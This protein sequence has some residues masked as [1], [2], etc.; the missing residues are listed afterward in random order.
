MI[1][2][3]RVSGVLLHPSS[4]PGKFGIG[5]LGAGAYSFVDWLCDAGQ[6]IWQILPLGPT[7]WSHSPYQAYSAFA[8]NPDL[9][10]LDFLVRDGYLGKGLIE[11]PPAFPSRKI[12]FKKVLPYRDRLLKM[13]FDQFKVSGGFKTQ[14]YHDFWDQHWWWLESWSLFNACRKHLP[15]ADWSEWEEDLRLR[16]STALINNM[17]K[18]EEEV[19]FSRFLQYIFFAQ[20]FALKNYANSKGISIFGDIPLYVAFN[21]SDVWS[22]QSLF[23]LD[24]NRQPT[25]VGGVPPD[26]FSETGQLWGN[27]LFDWN[28][29]K[30]RGY[31]WWMARLHFNLRMFD[32]VRIDHFR[33]LESFWA[34]PS[35][36]KTAINGS[37]MKANGAEMLQLLQRQIGSLPIVAEDLGLI[38]PEVDQLRK[39]FNLPGMKVLQFAFSADADNT[40]LPHNY[41]GDFVAY[42]GTHDNNTSIG[43]LKSLKREEKAKVYSYLGTETLDSWNL[44]RKVEESVAQMAIVPMQ[45]ILGLDGN[46]RM[47]KPGTT[48]GNWLWRMDPELLKKEQGTHLRE[49]TQLYGRNS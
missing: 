31:D 38:T 27:P 17:T 9:I 22:N 6:R 39:E 33:G 5:S 3:K 24:E 16:D 15:G 44:I 2:H 4:L 30:D 37:W 34:I 19:N 13:A 14:G 41:S 47:N 46:A 1:L 42:T 7:D 29:M 25:F 43:W 23:L 48:K 10:D 12:D 36:E 28:S 8:G 35:G 18:F 49:L 26:Y 40:H 20:W 32:M 45:D 11:N 21:S